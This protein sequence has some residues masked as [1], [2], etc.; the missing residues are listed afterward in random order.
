MLF[1]IDWHFPQIVLGMRGLMVPSYYYVLLVV[2][3]S[4]DRKTK[5]WLKSFYL[6]A[7]D[8]FVHST[9]CG[10]SMV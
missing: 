6:L 4:S 7:S 5:L 1:G 3:C 9:A 8:V 10:L 2:E